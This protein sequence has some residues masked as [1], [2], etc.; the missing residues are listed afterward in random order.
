MEDR[1]AVQ[2]MQGGRKQG[3]LHWGT[4]ALAML[5]FL[6]APR[7]PLQQRHRLVAAPK[8]AVPGHG[9]CASEFLRVSFLLPV[10]LIQS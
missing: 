10:G 7:L 3:S 6:A 2:S 9:L 1:A 4:A 5:G 8:C